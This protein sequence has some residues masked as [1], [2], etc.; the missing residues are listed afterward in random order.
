[1]DIMDT[2]VPFSASRH[3]CTNIYYIFI[4]WTFSL[5]KYKGRARIKN[6][7][8]YKI[9]GFIKWTCLDTIIK[10][11]KNGHNNQGRK[12]PTIDL[13]TPCACVVENDFQGTKKGSNSNLCS[14]IRL[15]LP[16][17]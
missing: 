13:E 4:R 17:H 14:Y 11:T 1:M 15:A 3:L 9:L 12:S 2:C 7:G 10:D 16:T 8:I 5:L 6:L